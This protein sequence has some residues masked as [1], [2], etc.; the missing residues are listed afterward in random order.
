MGSMV[1]PTTASLDSDQSV[2]EYEHQRQP[3]LSSASSLLHTSY[4]VPADALLFS[5]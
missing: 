5:M 2:E 3:V 4:S 1:V